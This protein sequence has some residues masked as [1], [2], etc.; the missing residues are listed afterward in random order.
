MQIIV[1]GMHR[2]GT[3]MVSRILNLM[4][5][6]FGEESVMMAA[7]PDNPKGFWE[8]Y[9]VMNLNN[10]ILEMAGGSWWEVDKLDFTSISPQNHAV[11]RESMTNILLKVDSHRPWFIKDPRMCLTLHRWLELLEL[12]VF[13][14]VLRPPVQVARSLCKRNNMPLE[15]GLALWEYYNL[16]LLQTLGSRQRIT[17]SYNTLLHKPHEQVKEMYK[18]LSSSGVSG[19]RMPDKQEIEAFV[20]PGLC[21]F[22]EQDEFH[23]LSAGQIRLYNSLKKSEVYE[24]SSLELKKIAGRMAQ[25]KT[26]GDWHSRLVDSS[27]NE[28]TAQRLKRIETENSRLAGENTRLAAEKSEL[29]AGNS[30]L[31]A[32]NTRLAVENSGLAVENSGLTVEN[33]GLTVE[34]A[35]LAEENARLAGENARLEAI[36]R[37]QRSGDQDLIDRLRAISGSRLVGASSLLSRAAG[38][39][40]KG[41]AAELDRIREI[42]AAQGDANIQALPAKT[43][44]ASSSLLHQAFARASVTTRL[45]TPNRVK[46]ALKLL[47]AHKGNPSF[48][49]RRFNECRRQLDTACK[50]ILTEREQHYIELYELPGSSED[51]RPKALSAAQAKRLAAALRAL[52]HDLA[53]DTSPPAAVSIIIPVHNQLRFTL[54]CLHSILDTPWRYR[55]EIIL[56]DDKSTDQT[57]RLLGHG[58]PAIRYLRHDTN[59]GFLEN[60]NS[61]ARIAKGRYLVFLNND[62]VVL[63][64]WLDELIRTFEGNPSAGLVGSKLIYPEGRLQEAGGIVFDD[65][66]AWNYG[67]FH[68]PSDPKFNY[69]RDADYC[70]GA[71]LAIRADLWRQIGGFDTRYCP[72]YYE[73]TDLA[74]QVRAAGYR[75]LYQ[76]LSALVHFEGI[77]SGKSEHSG[78]K[79]FQLVNK[80]KFYA[81]WV[82]SLKKH[83]PRDPDNLP[84]CRGARARILVVD[85]TTPTPDRDSGSMDAFNYMK[86]LKGLG[87]HVS[88]IPANAVFCE[89]YTFNLQRIGIKCLYLPWISSHKEALRK[90]APDAD[91]VILCRVKTAVPLVDIVRQHAPGAKIMFDT[92]DLHFLREEREAA[93]VDSSLLARMAAKTRELELEVI[94]KCDVSLFRST[95]EMDV[96]SN[97]V[98]DA[99]LVNLPIV[100]EIP[101]PSAV[102]FEDRKDIVF[103]G[104]FAHPP[105][106]DAVQYFVKNVWPKVRSGYAGRFIIAGSSMPDSIRALAAEDIVVRGYVEDLSELF[107]A[108]LLTVAPL[109]YGA[110]AKGKVVTSL[111]YGVPCVATPIA[112]EGC[113]FIAGK[114][115]LVENDPASMARAI[116]RIAN[117]KDHWQQL[118]GEGLTYCR[119]IF[120]V[121]SVKNRLDHTIKELLLS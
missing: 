116:I 11:I 25:I 30:G 61:A 115:L 119:R 87:F 20:D 59:K 76:P 49:I 111:S 103:I 80:E 38:R 51:R 120:S 81:K 64:G 71:S 105:N 9:D 90:L 32:E 16:C 52:P 24:P 58:F 112:A 74:F 4:G 77:S 109:R 88:F 27:N 89:E 79:R 18:A 2:S 98:P 41:L 67:R 72:A 34:N 44:S 97:L 14:H 17:V 106:I 66:S 54:A 6:Y 55:Y 93:L 48:V 36:N 50:N 15:Y 26:Q 3:S 101:G 10:Y 104:G 5:C 33:S 75:V 108:C 100:R 118:S 53:E 22:D 99:R 31:A 46:S 107:H 57:Q 113:G 92:V 65:G 39:G 1:L 91:V 83:G 56:A 23:L 35:R 45:I 114:H 12:P 42:L 78:V 47:V 82:E 121:E 73:D 7:A 21:H 29:A 70:S 95:H 102:P 84:V 96:V 94:R 62:T 40:H 69:L 43:R 68:D 37:K 117:D 60:C 110:G 28:T 86:I 19:L 13:I 85:A 63:P 8:R